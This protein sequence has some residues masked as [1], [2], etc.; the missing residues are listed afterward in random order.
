MVDLIKVKD[1]RKRE[2]EKEIELDF[3]KKPEFLISKLDAHGR[4]TINDLYRRAHKMDPGDSVA[5]VIVGV[6]KNGEQEKK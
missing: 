5:L 1:E 4:V 6:Y 2:Y 3:K